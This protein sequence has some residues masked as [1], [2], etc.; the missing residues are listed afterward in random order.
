VQVLTA[1]GKVP[2]IALSVTK[3][4][5]RGRTVVSSYL[6]PVLKPFANLVSIH[7]S[8]V[9]GVDGQLI[10]LIAQQFPQLRSFELVPGLSTEQVPNAALMELARSCTQLRKIHFQDSMLSD[11]ALV[12]FARCCPHLEDVTL[13]NISTLTS[14]GLLEFASSCKQ[15]KIISLYELEDLNDEALVAFGG[16]SLKNIDLTNLSNITAQS[17]IKLVSS[18]PVIETISLT[19]GAKFADGS[20][21]PLVENLPVSLKRLK[22]LRRLFSENAIGTLEAKQASGELDLTLYDF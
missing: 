8:N 12:E 4:D 3:L 13:R 17:F 1:L 14:R 16:D 7:L 19:Y 15:L 2:H 9:D 21:D 5:I 18:C 22:I 20:L 10:R 11:Q 6:I